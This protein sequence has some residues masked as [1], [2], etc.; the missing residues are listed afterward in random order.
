MK[1]AK[2][3]EQKIKENRTNS[4]NS[5]S[6]LCALHSAQKVLIAPSILSADFSYLAKEIQEVEKAGADWI[7]VDVMDGHFVPNLTIGP[8][9]VKWIRK[10]T[11]LFF[12][13]HLMI[14][15]PQKY[16]D[17]FIKAGADNITFHIEST[18]NPENLIHQIKNQN[19]KVG[20]SVRPKTSLSAILPYLAQID[21]ALIMTV[22]P[23]F[24]GQKFMADMMPKVRELKEYITKN[25]LKCRIEID[26]GINAETAPLTVQEG[27]D[28]LVAGNSIFSEKNRA[29]AL[30]KIRNSVQT[31]KSA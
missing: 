25:N 13:V 23:G 6:A 28:I 5:D 31:S 1:R 2:S 19:K 30:Q 20:L 3:K 17:E 8:V 10:I 21:L 7:H 15:E 22:E 29:E 4:N 11:P 9:I 12:D 16:A 26:G 24:G 27:A 18:P 14:D